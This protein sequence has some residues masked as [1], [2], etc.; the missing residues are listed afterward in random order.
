MSEALC[1][2]Y[3]RMDT[4]AYMTGMFRLAVER[5]ALRAGGKFSDGYK[6]VAMKA[7]LSYDYVYQ[8]YTGKSGKRPKTIS[9]EAFDALM[10]AYE[11][12]EDLGPVFNPQTTHPELEVFSDKPLPGEPGHPVQPPNSGHVVNESDWALLQDFHMLPEDEKQGLRATLK[13]KADHVRKIVNDYLGKRGMGATPVPDSKVEAAFGP[14]PPPTGPGS[15]KKHLPV[16]DAPKPA[17]TKG[18]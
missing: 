1:L 4:K 3:C 14:P 18:K 6:A 11:D 15:W 8:L 13:N 5:E 17:K 7:G 16:P 9:P 2:N 12:D 10:R